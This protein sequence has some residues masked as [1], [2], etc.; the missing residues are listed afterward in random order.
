MSYS[1]LTPPWSGVFEELVRSA[2]T[3]LVVCS[4]YIGRGPTDR[5]VKLV[6][7][8]LAPDSFAIRVLTDLSRENIVSGTTDLGALLSLA[9]CG[10]DVEIRFLPSLH[11]KIY[12]A[13]QT[14]AVVT[15]ANLTENG[16]LRNIEYG[17][18]F[19]DPAIVRR[20]WSHA[21]Q[22]A[23]LGS[24]I[25]H[26]QLTLLN[27]VVEE[28]RDIARTAQ[29]QLNRRIKREFD[30]RLARA[31]I[32]ILRARAAGRT[33]HAIFAETI[34]YLLR[35]GPM[36]T[37]DIHRQVKAIHPDLCDDTV[38]RVIDGQHFGK[39]WKHDVRSAQVYLR[40]GG[41]IRR[42]GRKWELTRDDG[43]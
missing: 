26:S 33:A 10:A 38:D 19:S 41:R 1:L 4:P 31:D 22:F 29:R 35:G 18:L 5:V 36:A 16:L 24:P 7:S 39:R 9:T 3:S 37:V 32:A 34:V 40:R 21:T 17:A 15:S 2:K 20:I 8:K 14:R 27:S 13:D 42:V 25:D 43:S 12:V 28:V 11:A 23:A 6:R 30:R